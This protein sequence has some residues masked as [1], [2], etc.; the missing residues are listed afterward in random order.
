MA[1]GKVNK[2]FQDMAVDSICAYVVRRHGNSKV[3]RA[4]FDG[5]TL[6]PRALCGARARGEWR[7]V[8]AE[9]TVAA[10][11]ATC[12]ASVARLTHDAPPPTPP[13]RA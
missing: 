11:C 6:H 8:S 9:F 2:L 4:L 12:R 3:H 5:T 10:E 13:G 1:K 7:V